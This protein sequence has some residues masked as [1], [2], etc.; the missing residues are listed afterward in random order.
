MRTPILIAGAAAVLALGAGVASSAIPDSSGVLHACYNTNGGQLRLVDTAS[1]CNPSETATQWSQ[2]GPQ[3]PQGDQGP[4]G[5]QGDT[6]DPG[7]AGTFS[8]SFASPDNAYSISVTNGG[9]VLSGPTGTISIDGGGISVQATG[10]VSVTGAQI[11]L[12]GC[13]GGVARAG[14]PITGTAVGSSVT[15][16]IQQGSPNVCAGS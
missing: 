16:T 8:G 1:D 15:G 4:P 3:G 14:D 2:T 9:I 7:P 10:T 6:G 11:H 13:D 5:P 12:N